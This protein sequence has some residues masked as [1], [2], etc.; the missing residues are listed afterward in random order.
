M[1]QFD[2]L[3]DHLQELH[4]RQL[5]IICAGSLGFLC[6]FELF[7]HLLED[8][9]WVL[10]ASLGLL[11]GAFAVVFLTRSRTVQLAY[12]STRT[13]AEI[14]RIWFYLDASG[15]EFPAH[16]WVRRRYRPIMGSVLAV[17]QRIQ[18]EV[19]SRNAFLLSESAVQSSWF[20]GQLKFFKRATHKAEKA[21]NLTESF[22]SSAFTLAILMLVDLAYV[23]Y[24]GNRSTALGHW[25]LVL[26]P[27]L[28]GFAAICQFYLE[29]RGFKANAERYRTS[30]LIYDLP[31]DHDWNTKVRDAGKEALDEVVDW[32]IASVERE[33]RVPSG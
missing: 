29:R 33:I 31:A 3:A 26:A 22:S 21:A 20:E 13:I 25:L 32:Y 6:G 1:L 7:A 12:L 5:N 18:D 27:S 2:A 23:T 16:E 15:E 17:R 11:A 28:L 10:L 8:K 4:F 19:G 24:T 30:H 9:V 14:L